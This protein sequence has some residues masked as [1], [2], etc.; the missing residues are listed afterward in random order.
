MRY[1][2]EKG[3]YRS[4]KCLKGPVDGEKADNESCYVIAEKLIRQI[5][6]MMLNLTFGMRL[7]YVRLCDV[8]RRSN[9]RLEH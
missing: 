7:G 5:T 2:G 1:F 3:E 4:V 9:C 6:Y 8:Y